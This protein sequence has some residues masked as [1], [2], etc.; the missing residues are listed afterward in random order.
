[1][2]RCIAC[3][4]ESGHLGADTSTSAA[5]GSGSFIFGIS[6]SGFV[7]DR[8]SDG[9]PTTE[10]PL[11]ASSSTTAL[12]DTGISSRVASKRNSEDED[13]SD[14]KSVL[15]SDG[16]VFSDEIYRSDQSGSVDA[17]ADV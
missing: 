5:G 15:K 11:T 6:G 13:T 4:A 17:Y 12:S 1:M 16:F 2:R 7:F 8:K 14:W 3:D 10:I 9:Q